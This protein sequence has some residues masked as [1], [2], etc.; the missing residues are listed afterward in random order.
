MV[1]FFETAQVL[2]VN[3][4]LAFGFFGDPKNLPRMYLR[5]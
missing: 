2:P 5:G 1:D 4:E 3:A